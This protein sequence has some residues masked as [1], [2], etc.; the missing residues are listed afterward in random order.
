[1]SRHSHNSSLRDEELSLDDV[2]AIVEPL[3]IAKRDGVDLRSAM[4]AALQEFDFDQF[5]F[6]RR[7][8]DGLELGTRYATWG[9]RQEGWFEHCREKQYY[10]RA[11]VG[12]LTLRSPEPV[13]WDSQRIPSNADTQEFVHD[14]KSFGVRSGLSMVI[15]RPAAGV[16]DFFQTTSSARLITDDNYRYLWQRMSDLWALGAYCHALLP[17]N[18]IALRI[19]RPSLRPGGDDV[20]RRHCHRELHPRRG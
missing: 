6:S 12:R 20:A 14:V 17:E 3:L 2:P 18:A 5:D 9:Q 8:V 7:R 11:P 13:I 10:R 15:C 1:M 16:V 19:R 4:A